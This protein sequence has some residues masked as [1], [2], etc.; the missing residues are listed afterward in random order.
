MPLKVSIALDV[1]IRFK[2]ITNG[3]R[4]IEQTGPD[5]NE[6]DVREDDTAASPGLSAG[7]IARR[8]R[9]EPWEAGT[10]AGLSE[11]FQSRRALRRWEQNTTAASGPCSENSPRPRRGIRTGRLQREV[12]IPPFSQGGGKIRPAQF[13]R[14]KRRNLRRVGILK[15][16]GEGEGKIKPLSISRLFQPPQKLNISRRLR[17]FGPSIG[18][19]SAMARRS[20]MRLRSVLATRLM[21]SNPPPAARISNPVVL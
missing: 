20:S 21:I 8:G 12:P 4:V 13:R 18:A 5:E 10:E 7:P 19:E 1:P 15:T 3:E 14:E 17:S 6:I 2:R 9:T 11:E 16:G